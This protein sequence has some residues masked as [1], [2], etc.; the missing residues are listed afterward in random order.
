MYGRDRKLRGFCENNGIGY[1]LGVP[2]SF[3]IALTAGL[4][5]RVDATLK[6]MVA[7][8]RDGPVGPAAGPGAR[9]ARARRGPW[10][11]SPT[12][13]DRTVRPHFAPDR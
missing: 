6:I 13:N 8:R 1:V 3:Q 5:M 11:P 10:R 4:T 7:S 2:C 12:A 9:A